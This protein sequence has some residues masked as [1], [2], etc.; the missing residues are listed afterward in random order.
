MFTNSFSYMSVVLAVISP[1]IVL[2]EVITVRTTEVW[3]G[4]Q[5]H[6]IS[7]TGG[8]T[9]E[10]PYVYAVPDGMILTETA[11]IRMND[12]Y[13]TFDFGAGTD[14]LTIAAGGYFDLTG[15]KRLADPGCCSII[16]G[17]NDLKGAGDFKTL[18]VTK[19]SM[20]VHI[21]G[22]GSV[23]INSVYARTSDAYAGDV[24][25]DIGGS[26]DIG[27]VDTQDQA[28]GG[29]SSGNVAVRAGSIATGDIDTRCLRTAAPGSN[30]S[31]DVVLEARDYNGFN[32][33]LNTLNL[34]GTINSAGATGLDGDITI[35]G[36]VVT[37]EAGS[38]MNPGNG[39]LKIHAG[40]VPAGRIADELFIDNSG[41]D[42]QATHNVPWGAAISFE[43]S[44][45]GA[46]EAVTSTAIKVA[47]AGAD[48]DQTYSVD[49]AVTGGTANNVTDF[50]LIP[51]TLVFAPGQTSQTITIG[52]VD[53]GFPEPDETIEISLSNPTGPDVALTQPTVHTYTIIDP[54]PA[55][56]FNH[57]ASSAR[58]DAG[59]ANITVSL[60]FPVGEQVTIGYIVT[61]R[62]ATS[63]SD[64]VLHNG[65][66]TFEPG[67]IDAEISITIIDDEQNE[68]DETVELNLTNPSPNSKLGPIKQHTFT[69]SD[70]EL[71]GSVYVNFLEMTF[72][73]IDPGTFIMGSS[74]GY[75]DEKPPREV[76]ISG[77]FYIQETEVTAEQFRLFDP[78]YARSGYATGVSSQEAEAFCQWLTQSTQDDFVYR[79]PTEAEWEYLCRAG[80]DTPFSSGN[81][82]P[83]GGIPNPWGV[84]NMHN[85]PLEWV[86]DWYGPYPDDNQT[87]PVGPDGGLARV[88]RGGGLDSDDSYY[89]RSSNRAGIAPAFA[90][91]AHK[92]GFR[93]VLGEPAATTP[94][95]R[96]APFTRLCVKQSCAQVSRGPDLGK[97]YFNQ[98]PMLPIPPD[99]ASREA[100]DAAGLHPSFRGHNH[101]P[102]MEVCSNGDVL[103]I[104]YTS[105]SEYEPEVSLMAARLR[106]GSD[107]WEMP[108]PMFDFPGANDHAPMLWNDD[109]T[110]RFFWGCPHLSGAY[111]FQWT[112]SKDHGANWDDVRFPV[113]EG[114][115]GSH[116]R[117]PINTALRGLDGTMYVSSDGS[118][119]H[120]VLW[121]S[122]N[123]GQ[124]WYDPGGRTGGRHT[125]FV[126]LNNGDIL[127]MGGKNTNI[128]GYM[129][130]SV[131]SDGGR[132]WDV[133]ITP[134]SWLGGNQRPC[135]ARLSTGRL[136]FCTD[137]QHSF[138]CDQPS[139]FD[140][141]GA[142]VALSEDEGDS[143]HIKKLST[144][145]PHECGCWPCG[146][147]TL[148]YS[149]ARQAPNG[150][151]HVITTMNH[152][153]QHFE[154]NEA[155]ILDPAAGG[156][157]P[158]DPGQA[159]AVT[160]YGEDYPDGSVKAAWSAKTCDD[161]RYLLHGTEKWY[162]ENGSK[163]YEVTYENGR[164]TGAETYWTP[165]GVRLWTWQHNPASNT[166]VWTQWWSSGLKKTESTW[167]YGGKVA[168][169]PAYH[170]HRP[171]TAS[172]AYKFE[173]GSLK[174]SAPLP[175]AQKKD[176]DFTG[177]GSVNGF[178]LD[179]FVNNWLWSGRQGGFNVADMDF[180]GIVDNTDL[181]RFAE[182]WER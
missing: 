138:D 41:S 133:G 148:G 135:V 3:D 178:D 137:F 78:E 9:A 160:Q 61:E 90:G 126:L 22:S 27:S 30:A 109:G 18:D 15:S 73:K 16:L 96:R 162:Y 49:Y 146:S 33:P 144:A 173:N 174:G 81:N 140:Q 21:T 95:P 150:V 151:I 129:P 104:I 75:W 105:Y 107:Q 37:L 57:S 5:M 169:G 116:S 1:C 29:N 76:T 89:S 31:G 8:G 13:V 72:V 55:V 65:T 25:I 88:V 87:D 63:G 56:G 38:A 142:L 113:F 153:C 100:I 71:G 141:F 53:D 86:S 85:Q 66:L 6:G 17:D 175:D 10:D 91:R 124:T 20:T 58:E 167:R 111:P 14:G 19:D 51:G 59:S 120:S 45:S 180:D 177:D 36:V 157:P 182:N 171:G 62:T 68:G 46:L 74:D 119:G 149:A 179:V 99:N 152:P 163:Q 154:M 23:A 98:R 24:L 77:A 115:V 101:S 48:R 97:P 43:T 118:G 52:I 70:D 54:R 79:L 164:K 114:A 127:G 121:A 136:F 2:S 168:H 132:T 155:W 12:R 47:L 39:Q 176:A 131:S 84:L 156:E 158:A 42:Y 92:I 110:L 170:W 28:A 125:S 102:G 166:S 83:S 50:T 161:G 11:A 44:S 181:A 128:N 34:Y 106:F 93:V 67:Q 145:L 7:P 64:Y 123:N 40:I 112:S 122:S 32:S 159:G 134:F 143:W 117:Q 103:M 94:T 130:K 147:A 108:T 60:A 172:A 139:G 69:I 26:A 165:Q 82:P 35:S 80:T 4:G